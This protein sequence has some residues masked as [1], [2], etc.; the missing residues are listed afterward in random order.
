MSP[1]A[2]ALI[3]WT[4]TNHLSII[5]AIDT[6]LS[7][8]TKKTSERGTG[9]SWWDDACQQAVRKYR[10]ARAEVRHQFLTSTVSQACL[11]QLTPLKSQLRCA[12]RQAKRKY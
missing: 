5:S 7:A 1:R 2:E 6:A 12:V 10:Q 3:Q 4:T 11:E 9:H 8:S